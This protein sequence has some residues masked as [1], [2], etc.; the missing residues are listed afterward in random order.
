MLKIYT[1]RAGKQMLDKIFT[2]YYKKLEDDR[3]SRKKVNANKRVRKV[4]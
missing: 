3:K 1:S 4:N 2:D